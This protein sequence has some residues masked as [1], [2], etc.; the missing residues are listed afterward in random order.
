MG[1]VVSGI[2]G[3]GGGQQEQP[4]TQT[5]YQVGYAPDLQP[6]AKDIMQRGQALSRQSYVP[7]QGQRIAGMSEAQRGALEGYKGL[8]ASPLYDQAVGLTA[9]GAQTFGAPQAQFY[10]SPYQQAV[11]D[12]EKR[13]IASEGA[14]ALEGIRSEA[15]KIGSFGG[16]RQGLLESGQ[17]GR[18]QQML[19]DAQARGSQA[20][21]QQA[22]DQFERD[23]ASRM[24]AAQQVAGLAGLQ[25]QSELQRLGAIE[26]AGTLEQEAEQQRL[27]LAY[28][29]FLNQQRQPYQQLEFLSGLLRGIPGGATPYMQQQYSPPPNPF[30][31]LLG[32]GIGAASLFKSPTA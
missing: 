28:Q 7:Y 14:K 25:Q 23:R 29:D 18:T 2:F 11:T 22:R 30:L 24:A 16:S 3:G 26:R 20:A 15:A 31:Q 13:N 17:I 10:M 12:I 21:F 6:Y 27:N 5:G 1:S 8:E 9:S 4:A 19:A 32:A